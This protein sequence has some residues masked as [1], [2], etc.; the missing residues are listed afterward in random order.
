MQSKISNYALHFNLKAYCVLKNNFMM[1]SWTFKIK[2]VISMG[3]NVNFFVLGGGY[4]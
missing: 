2:F 3:E 4:K 1:N